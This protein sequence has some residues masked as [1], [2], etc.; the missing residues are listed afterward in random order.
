MDQALAGQGRPRYRG[1]DANLT[2]TLASF[3]LGLVQFGWSVYQDHRKDRKEETREVLIRRLTT[4]IEQADGDDM[5][6]PGS[7]GRVVEVV[8][9]EILSLEGSR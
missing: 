2:L 6:P 9:E 1:L 3:L 8:V 7:R 5:L 4:R